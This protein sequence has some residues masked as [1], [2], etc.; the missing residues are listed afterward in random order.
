MAQSKQIPLKLKHIKNAEMQNHRWI[1]QMFCHFSV[2]VIRAASDDTTYDHQPQ[3]DI[4]V[5]YASPHGQRIR[6][7]ITI[8]KL[9]IDGFF[10]TLFVTEQHYHSKMISPT[11][12]ENHWTFWKHC[13]SPFSRPFSVKL[14]WMQDR[15]ML[16]NGVTY[17][18]SVPKHT[19]CN[20]KQKRL[21][22]NTHQLEIATV[23]VCWSVLFGTLVVHTHTQYMFKALLLKPISTFW[24][25]ADSVHMSSSISDM[26]ISVQTIYKFITVN[27]CSDQTENDTEE[28]ATEQTYA[29]K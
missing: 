25:D 16:R 11:A 24:L 22:N 26:S 23:C 4:H 20:R 15:L 1:M 13:Q 18:I 10:F 14:Q 28:L 2:C 21:E 9:W 17:R 5:I 3:I 6:Y 27:W 7:Q 29:A 8:I 12:T 19:K